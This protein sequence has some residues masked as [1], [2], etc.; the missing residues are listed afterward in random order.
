MSDSPRIELTASSDLIMVNDS[1]SAWLMFNP[2]I[3]NSIW[4]PL[5]KVTWSWG[6]SVRHIPDDPGN[7]WEKV[8]GTNYLSST[9]TA[10]DTTSFPH[11]TLNIAPHTFTCQ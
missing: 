6:G 9:P 10:T 2:N 1:A 7:Y 11:W 3:N 8:P 4:V 5:K